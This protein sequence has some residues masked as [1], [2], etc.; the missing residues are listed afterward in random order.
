[1]SGSTR[2]DNNMNMVHPLAKFEL[3]LTKYYKIDNASHAVWSR[4]LGEIRWCIASGMNTA[5][6]SMWVNTKTG[7]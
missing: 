6:I 1:M 2:E 5:C 4:C 3:K 7:K